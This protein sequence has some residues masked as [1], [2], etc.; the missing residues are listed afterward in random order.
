M[1]IHTF[2]HEQILQ[3]QAHSQVTCTSL[4]AVTVLVLGSIAT[5]RS[6]P[7]FINAKLARATFREAD[8]E[9]AN[10]NVDMKTLDVENAE[11]DL[12]IAQRE[13]EKL[14]KL[15]VKTIYP[16]HGMIDNKGKKSIE[17]SYSLF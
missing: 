13:L 16:G 1:V 12:V 4:V 17:M 7:L 14:K 10:L 11:N 8:M 5:T 6:S 15:D 3:R 9:E 2:S